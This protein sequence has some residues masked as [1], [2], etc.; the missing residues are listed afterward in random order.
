MTVSSDLVR[1]TEN[2]LAATGADQEI[3]RQFARI[4]QVAPADYSADV[5]A[6]R[7]LVKQ[8]L[9]EAELKVGYDVCGILP[10][11][12]VRHMSG[13]WTATAPTVPLAILRAMMGALDSHA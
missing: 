13:R 6:A 11:A 12:T 10:S 9:P 2:I 3:D 8:L 5:M 1:L 7:Q 4:F